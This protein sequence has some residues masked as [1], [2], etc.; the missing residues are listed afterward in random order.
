MESVVLYQS[1]EDVN[2]THH[3]LLD[4]TELCN[5]AIMI[6]TMAPTEVQVTLFQSMLAFE[7]NH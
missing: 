6:W 7:S 2:R 5:E 1:V 4:V 3:I